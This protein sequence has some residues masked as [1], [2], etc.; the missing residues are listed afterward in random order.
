MRVVEVSSQPRLERLLVSLA[1]ATLNEAFQETIRWFNGELH[2]IAK[3]EL[4]FGWTTMWNQLSPAQRFQAVSVSFDPLGNVKPPAGPMPRD[5]T[6]SS[7]PLR[8]ILWRISPLLVMNGDPTLRIRLNGVLFEP[9]PSWAGYLVNAGRNQ[10]TWRQDL[11]RMF[12]L[13]LGPITMTLSLLGVLRNEAMRIFNDVDDTFFP[14]VP[15]YVG[16]TLR[17]QNLPTT[18]AEH[19]AADGFKFFRDNREGSSLPWAERI[20]PPYRRNCACYMVPILEEPQDPA[21]TVQY[22][23]PIGKGFP[24]LIRDPLY[25]S[26]WFDRQT[27]A[28]QKKLVGEKRWFAASSKGI[29]GIIFADFAARSG[30]IISPRR[31]MDESLRERN[32]RRID[33]Q[34]IMATHSLLIRDGWGKKLDLLPYASDPAIEAE[35]RDKLIKRLSAILK[36]S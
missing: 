24:I 2:R 6:D 18:D 17:S 12:S 25:F 3:D 7:M 29:G 33:A 4:E 11:D 14:S 1:N 5:I 30:G 10:T 8:D 13:T 34:I 21:F 20:V 22:R 35:Y 16:Y 23:L 27:A 36:N 28:T 26:E 32:R 9:L 19:A 15:A 31:L